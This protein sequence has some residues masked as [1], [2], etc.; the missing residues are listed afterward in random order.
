MRRLMLPFLF[1]LVLT[2]CETFGLPTP[3]T[4]AE[5]LV[6]A[7]SNFQLAVKTA[8][9]VKKAGLMTPET[10][11]IVG[12]AIDGGNSALKAAQDQYALG[13]PTAAE[14]WIV[15]ALAYVGDINRLVDRAQAIE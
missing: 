15:R 9:E 10:E 8:T 1:I 11:K 3:E 5:K 2:G 6:A 14:E 4:T 7:E 12:L 13:A